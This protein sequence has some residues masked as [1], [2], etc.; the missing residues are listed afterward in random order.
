MKGLL[1]NTLREVKCLK[2]SITS[3]K[4]ELKAKYNYLSLG[5]NKHKNIIFKKCAKI[6]IFKATYLSDP[7]IQ[8]TDR[9]R[10]Y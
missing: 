8:S 4:H 6:L 3:R 2:L 7:V 10:V 1:A 9:G 5:K